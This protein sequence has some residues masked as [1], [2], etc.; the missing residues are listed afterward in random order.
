MRP[1]TPAAWFLVAFLMA[2]ASLL[3]V[4]AM[5]ETMTDPV[6]RAEQAAKKYQ[7]SLRSK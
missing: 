3:L 1:R 7:E 4:A 2:L 5:F 6:K